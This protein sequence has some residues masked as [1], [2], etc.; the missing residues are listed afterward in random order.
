MLVI[1]LA[2]EPNNK[3]ITFMYKKCNPT[4]DRFK[5]YVK[6]L[7]PSDRRLEIYLHRK[8]GVEPMLGRMKSIF[9]VRRTHLQ[10]K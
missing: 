8:Y 3:E 1:I 2:T 9:G 4:W 5:N 6:K 7:L 10:E